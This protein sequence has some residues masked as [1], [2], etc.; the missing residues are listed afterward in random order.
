M[1]G[2]ISRIESPRLFLDLIEEDD[3]RGISC[4]SRVPPQTEMMARSLDLPTESIVKS[5]LFYSSPRPPSNYRIYL[6]ESGEKIGIIGFFNWNPVSGEGTIGFSVDKHYRNQGFMS[7][8]ARAFVDAWF[9]SGRMVWID[10]KCQPDNLASEV[11][12]TRI[13][14]TYRKTVE[15]TLFKGS[16]LYRLK[17]YG[18]SR[19]EWLDR[20]SAAWKR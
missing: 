14:M 18:I 9:L 1:S 13:G 10:G 16:R 17:L 3:P 5:F 7:E 2:I 12:L 15:E 11:I 20:Q 4:S 6:K 19:E 8:A